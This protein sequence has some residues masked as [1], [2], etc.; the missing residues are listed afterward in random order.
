M[1]KF[2]VL[3]ISAAAIVAASPASAVVGVAGRGLDVMRQLN[4]ITLQKFTP[5]VGNVAAKGDN[6]LS[7]DVEGRAFIG[8]NLKGNW[9]SGIGRSG[10]GSAAS[11]F[12]NVSIVGKNASAFNLNN[13]PN[14][15]AGNLT[16]T[17]QVAVRIGGDSTGAISPNASVKVQTGGSFNGQNFNPNSAKTAQYGTTLSGNQPQDAPYYQRN[18]SLAAGGANDLAAALETERARMDADLRALSANLRTLTG[19]A[20]NALGPTKVQNGSIVYADNNAVIFKAVDGGE[21]VSVFNLPAL[22][23]ATTARFFDATGKTVAASLGFQVASSVSTIIINVQGGN[24]GNYTFSNNYISGNRTVN[25]N[26]VNQQFSLVDVSTIQQKII[27]NFTDATAINTST[28]F[29]G[30]IL[31]PDALLKNTNAVNGTVVV[32]AIKGTGEIHLGTFA[33]PPPG[34][35]VPEPATWLQMIAGFGV[36]G[37]ALRRRRRLMLAA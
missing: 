22:G 9:I 21:G 20:G 34:D 27:W 12:G 16:P 8:G 28:E 1:R 6:S 25:V 17:G 29:F 11:T 3:L 24:A 15:G 32:G 30:S 23:D 2:G 35:A 18:A 19:T 5:A 4:L 14:G 7:D 10:R 26:G 31:A 13:G 36:I 33:G 37:T